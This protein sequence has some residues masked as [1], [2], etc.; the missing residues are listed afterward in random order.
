MEESGR[1]LI[2]ATI[3]EFPW[4]KWENWYGTFVRT[5]SL[6]PK[7]WTTIQSTFVSTFKSWN[8]W[9]VFMNTQNS[10]ESDGY[11]TVTLTSH[12]LTCNIHIHSNLPSYSQVMNTVIF[13]TLYTHSAIC[14]LCKAFDSQST[15]VW[16]SVSETKMIEHTFWVPRKAHTFL[17]CP[18]SFII[19]LLHPSSEQYSLSNYILIFFIRTVFQAP[20]YL[21][22]SIILLLTL[23][24]LDTESIK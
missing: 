18:S 5:D 4:R 20:E 10:L 13:P 19:S 2:Q 11:T 9:S 12:P 24:S 7:I 3:L 16:A 22:S 6:G 1:S 8:Q 15:L 21:D 17:N 14:L 23:Y